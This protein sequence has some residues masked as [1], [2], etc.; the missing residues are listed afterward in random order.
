MKKVYI[1]GKINGNPTFREDFEQQEQKL[2]SQGYAVMNPAKL[3]DG[4]GYEDCMYLCFAMIDI[5]DIVVML[6]NWKDSPGATRE[7]EYAIKNNKCIRGSEDV[8]KL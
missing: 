6:P 4:L 7:Y 2:V 1:A 8:E 5:A 3:P